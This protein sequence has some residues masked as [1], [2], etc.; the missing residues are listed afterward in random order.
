M[1]IP[2]AC[3]ELSR[4]RNSEVGS[5]KC[6]DSQGRGNVCQESLEDGRIDLMMGQQ[7]GKM[8]LDVG[9]GKEVDR[10]KERGKARLTS[11]ISS[12]TNNFCGL[13]SDMIPFYL[14]FVH[15]SIPSKT[16]PTV[17]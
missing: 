3:F 15:R 4:M 13:N 14:T 12:R 7:Q 17:C 5:S 1:S 16:T 6:L 11:G 10:R 2:P 8:S 9:S